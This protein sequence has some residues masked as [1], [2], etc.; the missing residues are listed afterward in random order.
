MTSKSK[1]K[2]TDRQGLEQVR[3]KLAAALKATEERSGNGLAY[4]YGVLAA[5]IKSTLATANA[6]LED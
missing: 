2:S 3:A 4:D 1:S 5:H 6:W